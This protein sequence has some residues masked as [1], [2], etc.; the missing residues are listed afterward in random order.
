VTELV[1]AVNNAQSG[2]AILLADGVYTLNGAFLWISAPNVELRSASGNRDAVVLDGDYLGSEILT[3]AASNV[4]LADLTIREAYTHPIHVVSSAIDTTGTL[5]YNVHIIDP[6]EQG[7]KINPNVSGTYVDDGVIACSTI[8]LTDAGRPNVAAGCY[9]GGIDA[10][11]AR[12]W[13]IR[14]NVIKG[15]WCNTGLSEHGV[16]C[17]RGCRDTLVERNRLIDNARGVGFGL[18]TSGV[19][20]TFSDDPCPGVSGYVGHYGGI[21][22]NNFIFASDADLFNSPDGFDCGICFWSACYAT[23][24]HNTVV[25]TVDNFSSIEWRFA[26]SVNVEVANN[27]VTHTLRERNGATAS[28]AG[29]LENAALSLFEDGAMGDLHLD[30]TAVSA[31]DQGVGLA[32]GLCVDDIDGDTRD[33]NPDI[34]ADEF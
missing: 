32:P 30:A 10:H 28:L 13:V 4:T 31:I 26:S 2:D 3:I 19:A 15:F 20:R 24:V 1:N 21:V 11:Q 25:S 9:T 12:D 8:E 23:A 5:I 18:A 14:D 27:I 17:W 7:I 6:R 29:N 22:R 34:G 33:A 16:H